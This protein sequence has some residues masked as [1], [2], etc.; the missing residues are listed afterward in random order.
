LKTQSTTAFSANETWAML[1]VGTCQECG[2]TNNHYE[3]CRYSQQTQ[4]VCNMPV[5][6]TPIESML[7]FFSVAVF[8]VAAC[9]T[10]PALS[11]LLLTAGLGGL[12][13]RLFI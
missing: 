6:D 4:T 3:M 11:L 1:G 2:W 5:F 12:I 9:S 7:L 10:S 13:V 8:T